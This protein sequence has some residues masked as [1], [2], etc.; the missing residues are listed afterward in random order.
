MLGRDLT[1][2]DLAALPSVTALL[3]K[4]WAPCRDGCPVHAD[5]RR[6]LQHIAQGQWREAIDVIRERLAFACVCGRVCH[7]PCETNCRRQDVDAAVAIRE[8]KRFVAEHQGAGGATVHKPARQDKARVAIV[9]GGPAGL[10]A[11]LELA[12]KGYRPTVFEKLPVAGGIPATAVPAYRL[13]RDVVQIDVDW[14]RA[15]G[16]EILTG[17]QIGKDRGISKLLSDG[18]DAVLLATGMTLSRSLPL[19]GADHPRVFKVM[20]F[21]NAMTF[22]E[23]PQVG[24]NVLVIGGG[25]VAMDAARTAVRLGAARVQAMCLENEQEMPAWSWERDEANEEGVSFIH[26]RGPVEITVRAGAIVGVK[27]RKVT[28]VFDENKRF[29][30]AYDDADM[31]DVPCDTVIFAIGQMADTSFIAGSPVALDERG[32]LR[33]DARTQQTN[34][35]NVFACGEIVTP[36][37]S[38]VEACQSGRRAA[39]AIDQ[40]LSRGQVALDDTIPPKIGTIPATTAEKVLKVE[41]HPIPME[42]AAKR[43]SCFD[44]IDH[45]LDIPAVLAEARRCMSCGSGAEVLVDKCA[46]CLT[47][48]RVCPF[49]IPVV[50]DVARIASDK[51]QSCGI[52]IAECPAKAIVYKGCEADDIAGRTANALA[53]GRKVV[54]YVGGFA[55]SD[56]QWQSAGGDVEGVGAIYLHSTSRLSV[57]D[58]LHALEA[59]ADGVIV[60]CLPGGHDR[61]PDVAHRTRLRVEQARQFLKDIDLP[62]ERVVM[63]DIGDGS[64]AAVREAVIQASGKIAASI[65]A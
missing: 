42:P 10:A 3:E 7:H 53:S 22:G 54:A 23:K 46:A 12:R 59:G 38:V 40:Y 19:A 16:V 14:I 21:L 30:P 55:A 51:C 60:A 33:Y 41:R 45:T 47:C 25:N 2:R 58:L 34:L 62:A 27:A 36:P 37:G 44:A 26:R 43:R 56:R 6:Y 20:E 31:I 29:S 32:R 4:E 8:L 48:L 52:C 28:R 65:N 13:P 9:G 5:V 15:H 18:F 61:Y 11:A 1:T 63:A 39:E 24:Q 17:V 35:P 50:T 57:S 49:G 64:D